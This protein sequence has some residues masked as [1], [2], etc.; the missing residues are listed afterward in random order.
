MKS[1]CHVRNG[2]SQFIAEAKQSWA[3]IVLG[4]ETAWE[5]LVLLTKSKLGSVARE[6]K[7]DGKLSKGV[8]G[9]GKSRLYSS[10]L[11]GNHTAK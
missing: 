10:Q 9:P 7:L 1:P 6:C 11:V 4:W 8:L 3:R 2:S 5:L